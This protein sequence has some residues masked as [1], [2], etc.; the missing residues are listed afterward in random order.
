MPDPLAVNSMFG[1]IA[2]RYDLANHLLSGGLDFGWRRRLVSAVKRAEPHDVLDL[3]TGSGDVAFALGQRLPSVTNIVGVD[4]CQPMLDQA[5]IKKAATSDARLAK[6]QFRQG[7]ALALPFA[8]GCFDAI[9]IAFGL[10]NLSDRAKGLR[11]MGRVLRPGGKLFVLE[12]SQPHPWFRPL[13]FFYLK[14]L[15]PVIAGLVTRDRAAYDYLNDTI[16]QFPGRAELAQEIRSAGFAQVDAR[17]MACG[18]VALH[19][20]TR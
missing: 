12:F 8:D 1:R 19:Q 6:I 13:Y 3:A 2:G 7:D 5:E 11:E 17:A 20:A 16:T 9:T 15:L 4:F 10:R 18:A 14:N